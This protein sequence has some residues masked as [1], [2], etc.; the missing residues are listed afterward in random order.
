MS[1]YSEKTSGCTANVFNGYMGVLHKKLNKGL[2]RA[3]SESLPGVAKVLVF[4][5]FSNKK[6]NV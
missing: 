5:L 3:N 6:K 4:S 1:E 2:S